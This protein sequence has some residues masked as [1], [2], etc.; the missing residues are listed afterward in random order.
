LLYPL[1]LKLRGRTWVVI[2]G[3]AMAKTK[4]RELMNSEANVRLIAPTVTEQISAWSREEKLRWEPH[5]YSSGD[6]RDAFLVVSVAHTETNAAV[7]EEAGRHIDCNPWMTP[8]LQPLPKEIEII[9]P[10]DRHVCSATSGPE[11]FPSTPNQK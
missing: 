11:S 6:L 3:N 10:T 9:D 2:G 1:F 4:V 8:P 5:S 7:F